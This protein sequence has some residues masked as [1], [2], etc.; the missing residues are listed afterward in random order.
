[1][2]NNRTTVAAYVQYLYFLCRTSLIRCSSTVCS[3]RSFKESRASLSSVSFPRHR[4]SISMHSHGFCPV[5]YL[6]VYFQACKGASPVRSSVDF[7]PTALVV[8]PFAFL[9]GTLVQIFQR[10]RWVNLAAWALS[11]VGFGLL[12]T[13][14]ADSSTGH[15]VGYQLI[16]AAQGLL[17]SLNRP[18]SSFLPVRC[19]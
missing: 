15:W 7:L 3:E 10:Y 17:V 12:S 14:H 9:A 4:S 18:F 13:L 8:A 6:P 5:D 19:G 1:M 16:S 2:V 11:L